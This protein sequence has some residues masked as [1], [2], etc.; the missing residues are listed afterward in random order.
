[1]VR[2]GRHFRGLSLA[3]RLSFDFAR[4]LRPNRKKP[5]GRS[6]SAYMKLR[7]STFS[8]ATGE[9]RDEPVSVAP[10]SMAAD[11]GV[12]VFFGRRSMTIASA[13]VIVLIPSRLK[14]AVGK[15]GSGGDPGFPGSEVGVIGLKGS[16]APG[17]RSRRRI[18]ADDSAWATLMAVA[19]PLRLKGDVGGLGLGSALG[20]PPAA[21]LGSRVKVGSESAV[22]CVLNFLNSAGPRAE[23]IGG[24]SVAIEFDRLAGI[25][26]GLK[27]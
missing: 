21:A 7:M 4:T 12:G 24:E 15:P 2:R 10:G 1:M 20:L 18:E 3:I 23:A 13:S 25:G 11:M 8:S 14:G 16:T 6:P 27:S 26:I 17:E 5:P 19:A 9:T 22:T